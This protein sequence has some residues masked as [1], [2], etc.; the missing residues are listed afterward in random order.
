M[1]AALRS[2]PVAQSEEKRLVRKS[3]FR[4]LA[5]LAAFGLTLMVASPAF[6]GTISVP[7]TNPY[8]VPLCTATGNPNLSCGDPNHP[9]GKPAAFPI[10]GTGYPVNVQIFTIICDGTPPSAPGWDPTANCDNLTAPS[11]RLTNAAGSA[12][13]DPNNA[14]QRIGVFDGPSP[15]GAFNCLYP[16]EADPGNGLP[17]FTNCQ[18]R[19]ATTNAAVTSDQAF[20]T[21]TLP[22]PGAMVPETRYAILLPLGALLLLMG[23]GYVALRRRNRP[24]AGLAA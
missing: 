5:A 2:A 9:V 7:S 15:G 14:N 8:N 23:G 13:W 3:P 6:A 16:G 12:S 17:S 24:T 10:T 19:V 18:V 1:G 21:L 20:V 4:V 22:N 11:G